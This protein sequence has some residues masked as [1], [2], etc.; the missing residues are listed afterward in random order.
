MRW[1]GSNWTRETSGISSE[2][3]GIFA[4][5]SSFAV[6]VG[7]SAVLVRVNG[8]WQNI[9]AQFGS[10]SPFFRVATGS[11]RRDVVIGGCAGIWRFDGTTWVREALAT[12]VCITS[13]YAFPGGGVVT[14]GVLRNIYIGTGPRGNRPGLP[15]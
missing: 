14:G 7:D 9:T 11:S 15:P 8:T 1:N 2:L 12:P 4:P 6:A 3:Y 5:D 13:G 10:V